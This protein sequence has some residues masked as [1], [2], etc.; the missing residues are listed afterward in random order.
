MKQ[1]DKAASARFQAALA[2][3][4]IAVRRLAEALQVAE[5]DLGLQ[6]RQLQDAERRG[7]L[8]SEIPDPETVAIAE[9]FAA[10][11][12][13]WIDVLE[14]KVLV[15]RD[16]VLLAEREVVEISQQIQ[17]RGGEA[18][19]EAGE[20]AP[21]AEDPFLKQR[22]DRAAREAAAEA[23]LAFLKKKMGKDAK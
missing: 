16:E 23:Q 6:R 12:R 2:E 18:L 8:A 22:L 21:A 10:R 9:R 5:R 13:E 17:E 20:P 7:R 4:R 15:Q 1:P 14:R 11:H 19:H 3:A